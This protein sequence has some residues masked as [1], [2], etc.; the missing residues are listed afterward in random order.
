MYT[1]SESIRT[2]AANPTST[3][4]SGVSTQPAASAG[5]AEVWFLF[6]NFRSEPKLS[7]ENIVTQFWIGRKVQIKSING[8]WAFPKGCIMFERI[9][10]DNATLTD[11][12]CDNCRGDILNY[13][14]TH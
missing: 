14:N 3:Q 4:F 5:K 10:I 13:I 11:L 6:V 7:S 1:E 9:D 12:Y 8:L 2:K